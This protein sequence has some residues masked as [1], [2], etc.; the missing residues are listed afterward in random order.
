MTTIDGRVSMRIAE[1]LK[2]G[3]GSRAS[4]VP[5]NESD[6]KT[7]PSASTFRLP[8]RRMISTPSLFPATPSTGAIDS[9]KATIDSSISRRHAGCSPRLAGRAR[10]LPKCRRAAV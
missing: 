4:P 8:N 5:V 9:N 6:A 1:R 2:G 3:L 7:R 10:A